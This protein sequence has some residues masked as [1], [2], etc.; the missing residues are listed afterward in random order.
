MQD[1]QPTQNAMG[2]GRWTPI[3]DCG[4]TEQCLALKRITVVPGMGLRPPPRRN[5]LAYELQ[6]MWEPHI[7]GVLQRVFRTEG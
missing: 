1:A 6:V 7:N 4:A 2:L 3:S 5:R